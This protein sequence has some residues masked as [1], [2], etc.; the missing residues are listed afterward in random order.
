MHLFF[1][2]QYISVDMMAPVIYK[3]AKKNN[4]FVC[5][6]NKIQSLKKIELY[7][8]IIDQK[9]VSEVRDVIK[10]FSKEN[11]Y[12]A[13]IN[14]LL[15]LP[16][17][18]LKK[19]YRYWKY[20]WE[21]VNFV[22][23]DLLIKFI[24]NNKIKTFSYDESLVENKKKFIISISKELNIP[25]IMNHGGLYTL[26]ARKKKNYKFKEC[27]FFLSPNKFPIFA[28]KLDKIYLRSGKYHQLGSPR[29]DE[30][31]LNV[32]KKIFKR[33]KTT[34][35]KKIKVAFFVRPT[36]ISYS[37]TLNLLKDLYKI[38]N[39]EVKLNYKPR[40]VW[41]TKCSSIS[42]SEM[43]SS[44]LIF[45]SDLVISYASS[46][47]LEGICRNKPLIYLDYLQIHKKNDTS[48]FDDFVCIKKA[49]NSNHV[50][51]LI[52]NFKKNRDKLIINE[53][54]KKLILKN[55]IT[56]KSGRGILNKYNSFYNNLNK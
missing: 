4:V 35:K 24:K 41:P 42:R 1:V 31:W 16:A 5:N 22:S 38:E 25:L 3:L 27:D 47:I 50:I 52:M 17:P 14:L 30:E 44:E 12:L 34:N 26:K 53:L 18:F 19:G 32:L 23:R 51:K 15:L 9:N 48:W 21:N 28:N 7:K 2:D 8:F 45:W 36:S 49:K 13:L 11:F 43:Q 33:S 10:F 37:E 6:F 29:F 20:I 54:N 46:I 56:H 40:D 55:F 39:I